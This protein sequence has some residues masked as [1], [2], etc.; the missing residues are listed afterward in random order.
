MNRDRP[1]AD[2]KAGLRADAEFD[3]GRRVTG[4]PLFFRR[5]ARGRRSGGLH[6]LHKTGIVPGPIPAPAA[7]ARVGSRTMRVGSA[8]PPGFMTQSSRRL[9]DVDIP[10]QPDVL[11]RLSLLLAEDEVDFNAAAC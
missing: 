3:Q 9:L 10:A 6:R 7:T 8:R 2:P 11:V 1:E 5:R 4:A